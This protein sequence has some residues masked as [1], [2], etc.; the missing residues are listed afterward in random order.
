MKPGNFLDLLGENLG[1]EEIQLVFTI[2]KNYLNDPTMAE[3]IDGEYTILGKV[4]KLISRDGGEFINLLRNSGLSIFR[5]EQLQ[6]IFSALEELSGQGFQIP[7]LTT[8]IKGPAIQILPIAIF[9]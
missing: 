1:G 3:I 9:V 8:E 5:P 7:Q 2:E 6:E 4:S